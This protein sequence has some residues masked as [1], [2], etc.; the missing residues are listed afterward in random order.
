[1]SKSHRLFD[2]LQIL[3][4]HRRPVAGLALAR[5]AGVS[6]RTIRRDIASLQAMGADIQ[7]EAGVGYVLKPGFLLP[8]LMFS[9]EELHALKLGAEW[10]RNQT[11]ESLA[12][13]AQNLL[14][15]VDA[16]LPA[17]IQHQLHDIGFYVG[18]RQL[19][20]HPVD[21]GMLRQAMS[22]QR[23]VLIFY[24]DVGGA[25]TQ[26]IIWP[27]SLGFIENER[28]VASWCEM[29]HDFRT[30]RIDRIDHADIRS[31]HYPGDRRDLVKQWRLQVA[32]GGTQH[33]K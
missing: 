19:Q 8:P 21:L 1:M 4:R 13:A 17:G 12:R 22:E 3:R 15:K 14:A 11:D 6:L 33:T 32:S 28:Y 30:F 27:I 29:R 23:K 2:L 25:A 18:Q 31:E 5:E 26:R 9:E 10:V 7:G 20:L 24:R 16:M